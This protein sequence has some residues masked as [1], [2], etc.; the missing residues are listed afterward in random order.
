MAECDYY[1]CLGKATKQIESKLGKKPYF[2][3]VCDDCYKEY[4][5]LMEEK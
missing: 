3:D 5:E 2:I 1:G 4:E